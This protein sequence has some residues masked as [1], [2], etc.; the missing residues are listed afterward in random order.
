[1]LNSTSKVIATLV[2]ALACAGP[3][4]TAWAKDTMTVSVANATGSPVVV[5]NG[6][7]QG[8]IQLFYA[9]NASA[10]T[11]GEFAAFDVLWSTSSESKQGDGL[12]FRHCIL[13]EAGSAGR[14]RGSFTEP[15]HLYSDSD[16]AKR[17]VAGH[18]LH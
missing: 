2:L 10:F 9:V 11:V 6:V 3:A 16:R 5:N 18:R 8:T 4:G 14:I 7:A 12:R 17:S 1:M 15:E 13:A